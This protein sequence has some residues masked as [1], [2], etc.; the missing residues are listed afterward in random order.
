MDDRPKPA[1][2]PPEGPPGAGSAGGASPG[3]ASQ[4]GRRLDIGQL[5]SAHHAAVYRYAFRLTGS[6]ADAEDLTQQT[7]LIAQQRLGQI[8]EPDKA[9]RWLFAVLRSCFLKN[10]RRRNPVSA[11]NLELEIDNIPEPPGAGEAVDGEL[12]Q[13]VL[14]EL[15]E[16]YRL[17]LVMF[18]F[19]ECS[20]KEIAQQLDIPIGTVM[21]RLA[22]AKSRLR[23]RLA[24]RI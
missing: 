16:D 9:D 7:F 11:A 22:R 17:V 13:R 8:R 19:E 12:L 10:R 23:S 3:D 21:S 1:D 2:K 5:V 4:G 18:Y 15:P 20:Y 14:D 6:A 24:S